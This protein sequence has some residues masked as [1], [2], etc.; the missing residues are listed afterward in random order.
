MSFAR[1]LGKFLNVVDAGMTHRSRMRSR[2]PLSLRARQAPP[3]PPNPN[4]AANASQSLTDSMRMRRGLLANI[5]GGGTNTAP[6]T[7]KTQVGNLGC[8]QRGA[9]IVVLSA[10]SRTRP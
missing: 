10:L 4:D 3:A 6:V 1:G 2:G 8:S 5:Y 7:G 9:P